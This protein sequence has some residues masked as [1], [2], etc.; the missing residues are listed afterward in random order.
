M[1]GLIRADGLVL[2]RHTAV[3]VS[4]LGTLRRRRQLVGQWFVPDAYT[5]SERLFLQ[6]DDNCGLAGSARL[7]LHNAVLT[8]V[9]VVRPLRPPRTPTAMP[10]TVLVNMV[11]RVVLPD[12]AE[13]SIAVGRVEGS[14]RDAVQICDDLCTQ[15]RPVVGVAAGGAAR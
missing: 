11:V 10:A 8:S 1:Y 6:A 3:G 5:E 7:S 15:A 2:L 9:A 4:A 14:Q 12:L 13:R